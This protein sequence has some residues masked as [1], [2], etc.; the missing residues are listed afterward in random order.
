MWVVDNSLHRVSTKKVIR[1]TFANVFFKK[2]VRKHDIS[3][4]VA[5]FFS[6][7]PF[8]FFW[9]QGALAWATALC[10]ATC[11]CSPETGAFVKGHLGEVVHLDAEVRR[12]PMSPQVSVLPRF[13]PC[14][15]P[16]Y[17]PTPVPEGSRSTPGDPEYW[18]GQ[19]RNLPTDT[20]MRFCVWEVM[21]PDFSGSSP[22][23]F[24]RGFTK[25]ISHHGPFY[26]P[27]QKLF[28]TTS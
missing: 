20:P 6:I 4:L 23:G 22:C 26:F 3:F 12:V 19:I 7:L 24:L 10:G 2:K 25:K 17:D 27:W 9:S 21:C 28:A 1:K 5:F 18:W 13:F 14:M 16:G 15:Q 8:L 11:T